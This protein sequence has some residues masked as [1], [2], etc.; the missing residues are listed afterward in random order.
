[1]APNR[2]VLRQIVKQ[3]EQNVACGSGR[4]LRRGLPA[5]G[6]FC[7][8]LAKTTTARSLDGISITSVENPGTPPFLLNLSDTVRCR[9]G[10]EPMP[11]GIF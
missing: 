10:I 9:P 11:G 7:L 5:S 3:R 1:M 2:R 4:L 6:T 8:E